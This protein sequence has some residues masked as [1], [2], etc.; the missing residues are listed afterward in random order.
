MAFE[1]TI[2]LVGL[3]LFVPDP[4]TE[5]LYVLMPTADHGMDP[6]VA[7]L[8]FDTAYVRPGSTRLDGYLGGF[9]TPDGVADAD[10]VY[11]SHGDGVCNAP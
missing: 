2:E 8:C 4:Q 11:V 5:T 6:H 3:C 7:R 9:R 1:L 10:R